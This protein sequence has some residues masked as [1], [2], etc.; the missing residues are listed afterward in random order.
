MKKT[1]L[2]VEN[3][4]YRDVY[5]AESFY[6]RL[7][8]LMF[9][10]KENSFNLFIKNCNSIHTCFMKFPITIVCFDE[11]MKIVKII[12]NIKPFKFIFPLKNVKHILEIPE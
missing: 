1:D 3:K 2:S 5:I 4:T 9:V 8:G 6:D 12:K 10:P 7:K 11:Q